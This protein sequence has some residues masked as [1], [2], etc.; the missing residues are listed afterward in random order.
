LRPPTPP[1]LAALPPHVPRKI[2]IPRMGGGH[3]LQN[4]P[5]VVPPSF[6]LIAPCNPVHSFCMEAV[7]ILP[8]AQLLG[9]L[10][11]GGPELQPYFP[12]QMGIPCGFSPSTLALGNNQQQQ[13]LQASA[14]YNILLCQLCQQIEYYFSP[15]N[16]IRDTFLRKKMDCEGFV[17]LSE[18]C[19]FNRVKHLTS[20]PRVVM[21]AVKRSDWLEMML[22]NLGGPPSPFLPSDPKQVL[23]CKVRTRICPERWCIAEG[24]EIPI[25]THQQFAV[26]GQ[27]PVLAEIQS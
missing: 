11:S 27:Q 21:L 6:P 8:P 7:P 25:F 16:L 1:R 19:N 2:N 4:P 26:E 22:D 9:P 18:I 15:E 17:L 5:G 24:Q 3:R 12:Q 10:S 23:C 14:E 20:D 13:L